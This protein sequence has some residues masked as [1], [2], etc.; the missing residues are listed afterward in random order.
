MAMAKELKYDKT[1]FN[2]PKDTCYRYTGI[3]H[4][5]WSF[6]HQGFWIFHYQTPSPMWLNCCMFIAFCYIKL[7]ITLP[8]WVT[9]SLWWTPNNDGFHGLQLLVISIQH[10]W[11]FAIH[12]LLFAEG[13]LICFWTTQHGV[14]STGA[15]RGLGSVGWILAMLL[16]ICCLHVWARRGKNNRTVLSGSEFM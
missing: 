14:W 11:T 9:E 1:N 3:H 2:I 4:H 16:L 8:F 15:C 6:I 10:P 13:Y 12:F 7:L 5:W